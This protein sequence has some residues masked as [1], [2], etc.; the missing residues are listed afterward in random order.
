MGPEWFNAMLLSAPHLK[1]KTREVKT[2]EKN[3]IRTVRIIESSK[4]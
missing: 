1:V 2:Q 3:W 4:E